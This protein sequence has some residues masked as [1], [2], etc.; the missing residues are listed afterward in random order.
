MAAY[1]V[2]LSGQAERV[3]RRM[4]RREPLLYRRV[5]GALDDLAHDPHAGKPLKGRLAGRYSHRVGPYRIIYVLRRA[6]LLV[7]VIDIGHRREIYR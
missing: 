6:K 7:L 5:A 1:R 4:A 2:E 3:V